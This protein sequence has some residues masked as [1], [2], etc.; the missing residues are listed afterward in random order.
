MEC[1][2]CAYLCLVRA[3]QNRRLGLVLHRICMSNGREGFVSVS[4]LLMGCKCV[5]CMSC[6]NCKRLRWLMEEDDRRPGNY[7]YAYLLIYY[8]IFRA[9]LRL[10]DGPYFFNNCHSFSSTQRLFNGWLVNG[11]CGGCRNYGHVLAT[12]VCQLFSNSGTQTRPF[13][14]VLYHFW[15]T[16]VQKGKHPNFVSASMLLYGL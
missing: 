9:S 7:L 8:G 15:R 3:L 12:N 16:I 4:M 13:Q 1:V 2:V 10:Q 6:C 5:G 14:C 11:R